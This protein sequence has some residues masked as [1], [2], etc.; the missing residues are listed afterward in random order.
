MYWARFIVAIA[1]DLP[2]RAMGESRFRINS[3]ELH[4]GGF[5]KASVL[6]VS[7]RYQ[8]GLIN[9]AVGAALRNFDRACSLSEASLLSSLVLLT[10]GISHETWTASSR[11]EKRQGSLFAKDARQFPRHCVLSNKHFVEISAGVTPSN[12]V[13]RGTMCSAACAGL[14][15]SK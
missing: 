14:T 4:A 8:T 5:R 15:R 10:V 3:T 1:Q 2:K 11:K 7:L 12:T 9:Y 13:K 6:A